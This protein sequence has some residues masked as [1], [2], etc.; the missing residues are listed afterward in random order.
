MRIKNFAWA[1][2]P[3][4]LFNTGNNKVNAQR[5]SAVFVQGVVIADDTQQPIAGAH[6]YIVHGEEEALT[7]AKGEFRIQSWQKLP[8]KL[9]VEFRNY[10]TTT[11]SVGEPSR[12]QQV[13]LKIR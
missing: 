8:L 3:L 6:V 13:R 11:I 7:N 10:R 2:L 9:T 1:I 5:P 12:R 4:L